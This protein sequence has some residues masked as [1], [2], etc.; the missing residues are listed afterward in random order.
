[1]LLIDQEIYHAHVFMYRTL[2]MVT[3][4]V[5]VQV[6]SVIAYVTIESMIILKEPIDVQE[7]AT[8]AC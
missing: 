7:T 8:L 4:I 3:S 1:M 5:G 6:M 2:V